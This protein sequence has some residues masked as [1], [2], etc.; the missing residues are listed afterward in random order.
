M[1][2][3][4]LLILFYKCKI[5][6]KCQLKYSLIQGV[7]PASCLLERPLQSQRADPLQQVRK[8]LLMIR[9]AAEKIKKI[10]ARNSRM[11]SSMAELKG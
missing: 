1:E 4:L 9:A 3:G 7:F 5:Y 11:V 10:D 2:I 8:I 6:T